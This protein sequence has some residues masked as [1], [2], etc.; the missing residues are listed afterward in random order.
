MVPEVGVGFAVPGDEVG[1]V[2]VVLDE[3][4]A[5]EVGDAFLVAG[6][7]DDAQG[8]QVDRAFDGV[9]GFGGG[10]GYEDGVAFQEEGLQEVGFVFFGFDTVGWGE[11]V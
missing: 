4:A 7:A 11:L 10:G 8:V 1:R 5:P 3:P 2:V 9:G 6:G